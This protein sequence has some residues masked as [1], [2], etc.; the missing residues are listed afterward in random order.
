MAKPK[1]KKKGKGDEIVEWVT[2]F[3]RSNVYSN[4]LPARD[5]VGAF[6]LPR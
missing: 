5:H 2:G 3:I 1:A 4:R 6:F